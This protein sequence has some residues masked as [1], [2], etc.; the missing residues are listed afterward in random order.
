MPCCAMYGCSEQTQKGMIRL[1]RFPQNEDISKQWVFLCRR[2]DKIIVENARICSKHFSEDQY[3]H[4]ALNKCNMLGY[5]PQTSKLLL[6]DAKPDINLPTSSITVNSTSI[7]TC[8][9]MIDGCDKR[10]RNLKC[11]RKRSLK[12][13]LDASDHHSDTNNPSPKKPRTDDVDYPASSL[14]DTAQILLGGCS[15]SACVGGPGGVYSNSASLL[16]LAPSEIPT[17]SDTTAS[18]SITPSLSPT[19]LGRSARCL[20]GST[21]CIKSLNVCSSEAEKVN[22]DSYNLLI[23]C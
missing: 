11:N 1:H 13:L 23:E 8:K 17:T 10:E 4:V 21:T 9:K 12:V 20:T 22:T 16:L 6:T 7:S 18:S 14:W 5:T 2:N 15:S 19:K 3:D